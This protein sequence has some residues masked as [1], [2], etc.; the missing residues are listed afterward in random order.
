MQDV[1]AKAMDRRRGAGA[2]ALAL[3]LGVTVLAAHARAAAP[4]PRA[5]DAESRAQYVALCGKLDAAYDSLH[6]GWVVKGQPIEAAIE[7][8]LIRGAEG[9]TLARGRALRTL[10]WMRALLDSVG[11]GYYTNAQ[12]ADP[13]H[14]AFEKLTWPNSRRLDLLVHVWRATGDDRWKRDASFVQDYMDRVLLDGRGGFVSGQVGD[15]TLL[16]EA[17]GEAV[18]AWLAW[19]SVTR[20]T[21]YRDFA[22]KSLDR[23]WAENHDEKFGIVART[24]FGTVAAYPRLPD[25]VEL[26]L[27]L[28]AS[29]AATGRAGDLARA[30]ELGDVLL[31]RFEQAGRGFR[32]VYELKKSGQPKRPSFDAFENARAATFFSQLA[33]VTGDTRWSDAAQRA[34]RAFAGEL[35]KG[36]D[37]RAVAEWAMAVRARWDPALPAAVAWE[38]A[39]APAKAGP[40]KPAKKR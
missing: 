13:Y 7:L 29:H 19:G 22:W 32:E 12:S 1:P 17:N 25:H 15:R 37:A 8:G 3:V 27:A 39:S 38:A 40:E 21:R 28:L 24:E 33:A 4:A 14:T 23:L 16:P 20:H 18:A 11:G 31:G 36:R 9:D 10:E 34:H 6:G 35:E 26:G 2:K 30:R 5:P